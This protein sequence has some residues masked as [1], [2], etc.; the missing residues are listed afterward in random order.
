M[1]VEHPERKSDFRSGPL[2]SEVELQS[3]LNVA[4]VAGA[5]E[6]SE[7]AGA[8]SESR[9]AQ[10]A[11]GI[12]RPIEYVKKVR[13]EHQAHIF[14]G[15]FEVFSQRQIRHENVGAGERAHSACARAYWRWVLKGK[16]IKELTRRGR[17]ERYSRNPIRAPPVH[18]RV[19]ERGIGQNRYGWSRLNAGYAADLPAAKCSADEPA[20]MPEQR[21]VVEISCG[22][23]V[24]TVKIR[25]AIVVASIAPI[26][27]V[28]GQR[29]GVGQRL[30]PR[31]TDRGHE[32][33]LPL[34]C[35]NL[36]GVVVGRTI[37]QIHPN[38]GVSLVRA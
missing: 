37:A 24:P 15:Q 12:V 21:R 13:L 20:P 19:A 8:K 4:R 31:I 27:R 34:R 1:M 25:H 29:A 36:E 7:V 3:K 16:R 2:R 38:R 30:R 22:E 28:R 17:S 10:T 6:P 11:Q 5:S 18:G 14:S 23:D 35:V 26:I 9:V 33:A 32:V